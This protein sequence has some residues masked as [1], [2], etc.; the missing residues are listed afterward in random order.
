SI[1]G[2]KLPE[3]F[4]NSAGILNDVIA[5]PLLTG[6]VSNA[7]DFIFIKCSAETLS[8]IIEPPQ[9]PGPSVIEG[10]SEVVYPTAPIDATVLTSILNAGFSSANFIIIG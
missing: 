8:D 4:F 10:L 5:S 6:F 9:V 7:S 3:R 2:I 1:S